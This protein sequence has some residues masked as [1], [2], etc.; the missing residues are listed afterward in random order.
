MAVSMP[1]LIGGRMVGLIRYVSSLHLVDRQVIVSAVLAILVGAA[2]LAIVYASNLFFIRS[3]V[4]PVGEITE[5]AKRIAAGSYGVTIGRKFNDEIGELT[6]TI[7]EMSA[8]ISQTEKMKSEFLSSISHELRTPLTAISGWGE[9]L[10]SGELHDTEAVNKG[11]SIIVG[12]AQ[13]LT[14]MVE[15]LLDF[16]RLADGRFTLSISQTDVRSGFED[17]VYTYREFCRRTG[18]RL[19]YVPPETEIPIIPGDRT[20]CARSFPTCWTTPPSTRLGRTHRRLPFLR[21]RQRDHPHPRLRSRIPPEEL[22]HVNTCSTRAAPA[23]AATG[24][25]WPS[26]IRSSPSMA[27]RSRWKTRRAAACSSRSRFPSVDNIEFLCYI[28]GNECIF[29]PLLALLMNFYYFI[30]E[31]PSLCR[32]ASGDARRS[33]QSVL[34]KKIFGA[35]GYPYQ[36]KEFPTMPK[37]PMK[38]PLVEL[39]GDEMTRILWRQVKDILLSPYVDLR[40]VITTSACR[41]ARR[42]ATASPWRPRRPSGATAWA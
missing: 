31:F 1:I 29:M 15:E 5:T 36:Q 35:P 11:L 33:A 27:A 18:I 25:V 9:T 7:N 38:T 23:H 2:I 20:G 12:E 13:R 34:C 3:I 30:L 4:E 32:A 21:G 37:I 24:S 6:D 41:S 40:T 22:A 26:A 39:D 19:E 17:A 16:S 10:L 28:N 42:R 8:K 14:Q